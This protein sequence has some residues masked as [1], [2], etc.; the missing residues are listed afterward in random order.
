MHEI[1]ATAAQGNLRP[2]DAIAKA[3]QRGFFRA[4]L[5]P[6]AQLN[7]IAPCQCADFSGL[8]WYIDTPS[9]LFVPGCLGLNLL[10]V[11]RWNLIT[12]PPFSHHTP[13]L[14]KPSVTTHAEERLVLTGK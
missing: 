1:G 13:Y 7:L 4:V 14:A 2:A 6:N 10:G 11:I 8:G 12:W 5:R 3:R 9:F